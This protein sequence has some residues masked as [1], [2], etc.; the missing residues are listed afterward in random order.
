MRRTRTTTA[1][2]WTRVLGTKVRRVELLGT[3]R[4]QFKLQHSGIPPGSR[5][6]FRYGCPRPRISYI[7]GGPLTRALGEG[8]GYPRSRNPLLKSH[9]EWSRNARQEPSGGG[10]GPRVRMQS[11]RSIAHGSKETRTTETT[12]MLLA[13]ELRAERPQ[14][15]KYSEISARTFAVRSTLQGFDIES[16]LPSTEQRR[17]MG[18]SLR[19]FLKGGSAGIPFSFYGGNPFASVLSR[20]A[21][22]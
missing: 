21:I 4:L 11:T 15:A 18:A 10:Q 17:T 12:G 9:L 19:S 2:T 5:E 14:R 20:R 16:T 8:V 1:Q 22:G 7:R 6:D 13:C 3:S